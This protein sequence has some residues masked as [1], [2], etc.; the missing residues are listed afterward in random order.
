MF[1]DTPPSPAT[2]PETGTSV[3]DL[4][5]LCVRQSAAT[6]FVRAA[7]DSMQGAGIFDGDIL[8]VDRSLE[9]R[10]GDIVI[11]SLD[12]EFLLKILQYQPRL[13]LLPANDNYPPIE[14]S[15]GQWFELFGV[16]TFAIGK[17][18]ATGR[19]GSIRPGALAEPQ[20]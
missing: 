12:G 8:V 15:L 9:A 2:I 11:A 19:E 1:P 14:P 18:A 20:Q 10:Q 5:Q 7:G 16:V 4:N 17:L 3:L 13:R 6:Y